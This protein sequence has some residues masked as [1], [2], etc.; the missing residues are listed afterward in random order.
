MINSSLDELVGPIGLHPP[1][2]RKDLRDLVD[3]SAVYNSLSSTGK[4][5]KNIRKIVAIE[6][7]GEEMDGKLCVWVLI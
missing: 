3:S 7:M 6:S 4:I 5:W 2:E 1:D